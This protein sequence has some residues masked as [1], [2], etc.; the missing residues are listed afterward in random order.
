MLVAGGQDDP[1]APTAP[2]APTAAEEVTHADFCAGFGRLASARSTVL[3]APGP[4]AV[5][6]LR[7][8]AREVGDL[9][10]SAELPA[11]A[12]RGATTVADSL[13]ALPDTAGLDEVVAVDDLAG[14]AEADAAALSDFIGA[15]CDTSAPPG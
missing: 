1:P 8:A 2:T 10:R 4:D 14:P 9:A 13:A 7:A 5:A 12:R 6:S 11:E 15:T 3:S